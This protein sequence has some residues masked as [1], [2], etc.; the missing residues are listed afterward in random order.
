MIIIKTFVYYILRASSS[1]H[2]HW[3]L[4]FIHISLK[5]ASALPMWCKDWVFYRICI[6]IICVNIFWDL[7]FILDIIYQ[8]SLK[9]K[10]ISFI[11]LNLINVI[12]LAL[13]CHERLFS[14]PGLVHLFKVVVLPFK[15]LN[16]LP[17]LL[18]F[19]N[20]MLIYFW[21]GIC[22]TIFEWLII[23]ILNLPISHI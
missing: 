1:C 4:P 9:N 16:H 19:I 11:I 20:Q 22:I 3:S 8:P 5:E 12:L 21:V 13:L 6:D 23:S 10:L 17:R 7:I 2:L 15:K 14:L 18:L